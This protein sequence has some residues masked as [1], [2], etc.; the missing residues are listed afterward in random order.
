MARA[1]SSVLGALAGAARS[2][3]VAGAWE[4]PSRLVATAGFLVATLLGTRYRLAAL[5]NAVAGGSW[6]EPVLLLRGLSGELR[7]DLTRD[8]SPAAATMRRKGTK[9]STACHQ[10]EGSPPSPDGAH[11]EGEMEQ[12]ADGAE[13]AASAG[14]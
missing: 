14:E 10:E 2:L 13:S 9:P 6:A 4:N 7:A 8:S 3:H 11:G 5:T 1:N 12:P